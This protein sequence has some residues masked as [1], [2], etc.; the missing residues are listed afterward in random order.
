M[1]KIKDLK[2]IQQAVLDSV[3]ELCLSCPSLF[4]IVTSTVFALTINYGFPLGG[5]SV[6]GPTIL[7]GK[8]ITAE[9]Y[10]TN[11]PSTLWAK[12]ITFI[13]PSW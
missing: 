3:P 7:S 2:T 8:S 4:R 5:K 11:D 1:E 6:A 12:F 13:R 10:Q 9:G